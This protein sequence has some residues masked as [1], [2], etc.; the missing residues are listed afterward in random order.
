MRDDGLE[1]CC[2]KSLAEELYVVESE[3]VAD[4]RL[5]MFLRVL[6]HHNDK[7]GIGFEK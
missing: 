3:R 1:C 4:E 5:K 6:E 2:R 7:V